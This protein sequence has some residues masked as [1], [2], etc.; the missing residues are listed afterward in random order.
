MSSQMR[1]YDA[2]GRYGGEEFIIVMPRGNGTFAEVVGERIRES[3]EKDK[4]STSEEDCTGGVNE[5]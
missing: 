5:R 1:P 2:L 3:I 4:V